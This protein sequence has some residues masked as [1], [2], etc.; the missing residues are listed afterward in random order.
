MARLIA[1]RWNRQSGPGIWHGEPLGLAKGG[2][3]RPIVIEGPEG[4]YIVALAYLRPQ[5]VALTL[6]D[7]GGV[8]MHEDTKVQSRNEG[9]R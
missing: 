2:V 9:L 5:M 1:V 3:V 4:I 7:P 8:S 6:A